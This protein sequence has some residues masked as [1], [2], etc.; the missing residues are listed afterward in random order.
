MV[1]HGDDRTSRMSGD[2]GPGEAGWTTAFQPRATTRPE[3]SDS[4]RLSM[5][6]GIASMPAL[7]LCGVGLALA[8]VSLFAAR[9]AKQEIEQPRSGLYGVSEYRTGVVCS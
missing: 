2:I 9:S 5:I 7:M 8:A 6:L 1:R 3:L 4:A